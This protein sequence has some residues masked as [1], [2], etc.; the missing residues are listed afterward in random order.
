M[1]KKILLVREG[2][3]SPYLHQLAILLRTAGHL[4]S[5]VQTCGEPA[6]PLYRD[7]I[8]QVRAAGI[9]T[10]VIETRPHWLPRK[11]R[12]ALIRLG[13]DAKP[14][15]ITGTKV[16]RAQ[17]AVGQ[18][19]YD[20]VI[21]LDPP[22]LYLAWKL[23][24]LASH[25]LIDYSL[26]VADESRYHRHFLEFEREMLPHLGALIIQD[27]FRANVLLKGTE[28][29]SPR[30]I[31]YFPIAI[32]GAPI[33]ARAN[34][35]DFFRKLLP[36]SA[37]RRIL[38]FGG[39]WDAELMS[40]LMSQAQYLSGDDVLILHGAK[41]NPE[42][43]EQIAPH[44]LVS[45]TPV[46]FDR[47]TELIA[48]ADIGLALYPPTTLNAKF[49]AFSSEKISR[50]VQCGLPIIAFREGNFEYL[51]SET[52]CC[53]LISHLDE[54]PNAIEK[55]LSEYERYRAGAYNAYERFYRLENTS[56][57]LLSFLAG[58]D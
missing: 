6:A 16:A 1:Q 45:R 40:N 38:F 53:E 32:S 31:I 26:E 13:C 44:L 43:A 28:E 4:V 48:S 12:S 23:F 41:G 55:I 20:W 25:K 54:L 29:I 2:D 19:T 50:Y 18:E 46:G 9:P 51:Q 17:R 27:K 37:G 10:H 5:V 24:P 49:I 8:D 36:N 58:P 11:I 56:K 57:D 42:P 21:A 22:S 33:A 15:S 39:F 52:D 47:L 7:L 35:Q 14:G 30:R 3:F 34:N